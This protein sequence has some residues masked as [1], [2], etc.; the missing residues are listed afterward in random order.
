MKQNI[1]LCYRKVL[2]DQLKTKC[3]SSRKGAVLLLQNSV[4]SVHFK[5]KHTEKLVD[6]NVFIL[7][8]RNQQGGYYNFITKRGEKQIRK[9]T[10]RFTPDNVVGR[11]TRLCLD[12]SRFKFRQGQEILFSAKLP[13]RL[14]GPLNR[15][16]NR[17]WVSFPGVKSPESKVNFLPQSCAEVK[18]EWN[19]TSSPS[20][21]LHFL[22]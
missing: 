22:F 10:V 3:Y 9:I 7:Y 16:L 15:L 6:M 11:A 12:G 19:Y 17:P 5:E 18:N 2:T 20:L 1:N 4:K 13:H 21:C 8:Y 14:W